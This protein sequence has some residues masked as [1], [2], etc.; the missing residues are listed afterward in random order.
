MTTEALIKTV[1]QAA[2]KLLQA[3]EAYGP[4][5][6]ELVLATG[7]VAALQALT[8]GFF[9]LLMPALLIPL[10][11]FFNKKHKSWDDDGWQLVAIVCVFFS[12]LSVAASYVYLT[13]WFAW[14]GLSRPEVYLTAKL[15]GLS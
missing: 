9:W 4:K 1:T 12:F 14:V 10:A 6:T 7:K 11:F 8:P 15:L 5:A 2:D 3:I 13:N